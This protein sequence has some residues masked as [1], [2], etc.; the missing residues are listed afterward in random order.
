ME[1]LCSMR[2]L[3]V[4]VPVEIKNNEKKD[5]WFKCPICGFDNMITVKRENNELF[6]VD[7]DWWLT[8]KHFHHFI[9]IN[10]GKIEIKFVNTKRKSIPLFIR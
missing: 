3:K 5:I 4:I 7:F 10:S 1:I 9:P 8:C 2:L 6:G